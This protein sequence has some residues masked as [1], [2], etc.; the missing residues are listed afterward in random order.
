MRHR[1]DAMTTDPKTPGRSSSDWP[2]TSAPRP[3]DTPE[4]PPIQRRGLLAAMVAVAAAGLGW[5]GERLA[6]AGHNT[7]IA[8]SSQTVMHMDVTNTGAGSTR[9]NSNISGTAAFVALNNYPVGISRPDGMLG[10]TAYTTSNCAG[11]AGACE[12]ASGGIGVLGTAKSTTG[13][14][15]YGFAGSVVPSEVPPAGCGVHGTGPT[16]GVSGKSTNGTGVLGSSTSGDGVLGYTGG[17]LKYSVAGSGSGDAHGVVGF[18]ANQFGVIGVNQSGTNYAGFF[19]GG[20]AANP[21]VLIDGTFVATG[22]KSQAVPTARHGM[23]KLY[24]VEATRPM[25][26]D[27][28]TARLEDGEARVELDPVFAATVNTGIAYHVFVTPRGE[29]RGLYV[30]EQDPSGFVV[31]ELQRGTSGIAF[32]YRVMAAV[33]GHERTRLEPFTLPA[34]PAPPPVPETTRRGAPAEP[35]VAGVP[36]DHDDRP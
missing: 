6:G 17:S 27:V 31:R 19:S 34:V 9:I 16:V 36:G 32:D 3:P 14:G 29:C 10:R 18:S 23:R 20:G 13:T 15:V 33:R 21:G 28:G 22:T 30:S 8:Y 12:A 24:A 11:V 25:F 35:P 2:A 7:N 4:D 26:E 1:E 5:V